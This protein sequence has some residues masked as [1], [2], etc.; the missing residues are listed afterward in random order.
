MN[1]P[2]VAGLVSTMVFALSAL[3]MLV[4]AGRTK[5]LTSYSASNIVLSNVGNVVHSV[6]V[7]SLPPGPVWLL[8]TFYVISSA[9]M[10]MW[11]PLYTVRQRPEAEPSSDVGQVVDG[12]ERVMVGA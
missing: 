11:Y 4:K 6:Y 3:P 1:L 8:H 2:V 12:N 5:D 10:L 7:F 9:L